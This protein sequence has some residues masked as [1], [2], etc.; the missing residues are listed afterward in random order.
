M[1]GVFMGFQNNKNNLFKVV[2]KV[3]GKEPNHKA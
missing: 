3:V 1:I 2:K